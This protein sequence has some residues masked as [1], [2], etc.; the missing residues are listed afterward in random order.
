MAHM[1]HNG[2]SE[3][4]QTLVMPKLWGLVWFGLVW[5]GGGGY[6][7]VRLCF[8]I[9]MKTV[10]LSWK[11]EE[12]HDREWKGGADARNSVFSPRQPCG[13]H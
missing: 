9:L 12:V 7:F 2:N 11:Q 6:F 10:W 4:P 8:Q 3:L 5:S 1:L 13:I